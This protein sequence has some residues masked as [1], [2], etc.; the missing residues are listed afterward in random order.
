MKTSN[1]EFPDFLGSEISSAPL[2]K[3][4]FSVLPVPFERSVSFGR[5]TALGPKAILEAS[6][7]LETWDGRSDPSSAGIHTCQPVDCGGDDNGVLQRIAD[8]VRNILTAGS[9][10]VVIGGEHTITYG[11]VLGLIGAG[12]GDFGVVQFD[13]HADLRDSYEGN[14]LS[15][16]SVMKRIIDKGIPICQFGVRALC[17]EEVETRVRY[18]IH[19]VDARELVESNI[20]EAALPPGFPDKV[21]VTVDIDGLDPSVFP[22]TGTPV[23]GGLAWYQLLSMF[24]SVSRQRQ[25]IGFDVVEFSPI[26]GF[27]GYDFSAALLI[28]QLMG[29]VGRR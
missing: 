28:Y 3:A 6:W 26:P 12:I 23:P 18:D 20:R 2:K 24:E 27:H 21:F 22:S 5:G 1:S 25:V 7:Q 15:H 4:A 17:H 10:P 16:A 29:I 8:S 14:P 19:Y 11:N 9:L 13:A